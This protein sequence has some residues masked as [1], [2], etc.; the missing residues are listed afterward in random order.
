M[1]LLSW[2]VLGGQ[3]PRCSRSPQPIAAST[4]LDA[5]SRERRETV[6]KSSLDP[7]LEQ[8]Y[9][10]PKPFP[11]DWQLRNSSWPTGCTR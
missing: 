2:E 7:A 9:G 11:A 6:M 1:W 5:N 3:E 8:A 4:H 10:T